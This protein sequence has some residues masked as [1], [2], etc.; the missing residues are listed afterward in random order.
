MKDY[1]KIISREVDEQNRTI[2]V[3]ENLNGDEEKVLYS[4]IDQERVRRESGNEKYSATIV[5]KSTGE[6]IVLMSHDENG[7]KIDESEIRME[8][9]K[10]I[11]PEKYQDKLPDQLKRPV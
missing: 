6:K 4:E 3:I 9:D 11:N 5:T 1:K 8:K 7:N 2:Y 10:F